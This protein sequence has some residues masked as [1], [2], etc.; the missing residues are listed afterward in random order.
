LPEIDQIFQAKYLFIG[1][2]FDIL[3]LRG[4]IEEVKEDERYSQVFWHFEE[5]C[6]ELR[7]PNAL[8]KGAAEAEN[9]SEDGS[10]SDGSSD[11]LS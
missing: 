9:G 8:Q 4:V 1:R 10:L 3:N 7:F 2:E 5:A 11:F 6:E